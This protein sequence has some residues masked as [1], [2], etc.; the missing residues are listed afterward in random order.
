MSSNRPPLEMM[1]A[2]VDW[3]PPSHLIQQRFPIRDRVIPFM[4]NTCLN[5]ATHVRTCIDA[6]AAAHPHSYAIMSIKRMANTLRLVPHLHWILVEDANET[7]PYVRK[8]LERSTIPFTYLAA[9][10]EKGYPRRG[11][12]QRTVALRYLRKKSIS[13]MKNYKSG[14][15]YFADDDN[16]YD[17]RLFTDYIRHVKR[18]GLWAVGLS[19]RRPVEYP[20]VSNGS[21]IRFEAWL[22]SRLFATDMAGFAVNLNILLN[23][24][25]EF[26]KGCKKGFNSPE[27]C[28]LS[29]L[30]FER[31]D[32]EPFG[33]DSEEEEKEVLVWH[34][35]T[36]SMKF[37][38]TSKPLPYAFEYARKED[39]KPKIQVKDLKMP[40]LGETLRNIFQPS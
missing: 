25:V 24:T 3:R 38:R 20:V 7:V 18:L 14:V 33:W 34:T 30:G 5:T 35:K 1:T 10:T 17:I 6:D 28:F 22:P 2:L 32:I 15:V 39:E 13:L 8:I 4:F 19:G 31:K 29:D 21:V 40:S 36:V 11:W 12:F 9:G 37:N 16:S 23:S 27:T 26:G